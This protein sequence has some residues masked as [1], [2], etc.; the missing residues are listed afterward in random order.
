M[1]LQPEVLGK[2]RVQFIEPSGRVWVSRG[3]DIYYSDDF[4]AS[5]AFRAH[6]D[7]GWLRRFTSKYTLPT[8]F[9]RAGFLD[10]R[11]LSDGS[12]L[13]A[14]YGGIVRCESKGDEFF[15]VFWR[16]GRRMKIEV[17]S[18]G[19][20]V[21]GEY[22]YNKQRNAVNI[23]RSS[24]GGHTWRSAYQ[25]KAGEIRHI[26]SLVFDK[27]LNSLLILTGDSDEESK[28]LFTRDLFASLEVL[29]QGTQRSRALAI[30]P[31]DGGYLI[32]TDTPFEQ[33]YIQFLSFERELS[34]RCPIVGSCLCG[35]QVGSWSLFATAAEPSEVNRE[36]HITLYG[37]QDG[38]GW[39]ILYQWSV[40][41]WSWPTKLQAAAFE[42]GR[43]LLPKGENYTGYLFATPVAVREN[44]GIL[45]RWRLA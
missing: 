40:D 39:S 33:N 11:P 5:F 29:S 35:C 44:E 32:A 31:V 22:F 34:L 7:P 25:F 19:V 17:L 18:G 16:P 37:T 30:L 26:H 20:I 28:V 3:N 1:R 8:R 23:M 27:R 36:P 38:Y 42:M 6:F 9:L 4:G 12:V 2:Y 41:W 24:D 43:L 21:A 45:H 14:V 13:G 15:K 10:I